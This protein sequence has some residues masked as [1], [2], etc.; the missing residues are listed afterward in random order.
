M[1]SSPDQSS[2]SLVSWQAENTHPELIGPFREKMR[3]VIDPELG[4]NIIELG[5]IRDLKVLEGDAEVTMILTTPFCPYAPAMMEMTR[6]KAETV[7]ERPVTVD[8]GMEMWEPS[9]MEE[10]A[11]A[12]W[13]LF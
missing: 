6:N 10:G 3:E 13:G 1:T 9:M 11:G 2:P 7:L 4:L 8:M 12:D 5:L